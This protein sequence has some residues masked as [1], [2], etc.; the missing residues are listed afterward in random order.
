MAINEIDDMD[1]EIVKVFLDNVRAE[2]KTWEKGKEIELLHRIVK[3]VKNDIEISVVLKKDDVYQRLIANMTAQLLNTEINLLKRA[4]AK[5]PTKQEGKE[6]KTYFKVKS[7]KCP[8]CEQL[9]GDF[10]IH[11]TK[12]FDNKTKKYFPIILTN[13]PKCDHLFGLRNLKEVKKAKQK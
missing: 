7:I 11:R 10:K 2:V 5:D 1:K 4:E 6:E 13:C 12:V 8:E 3:K 9:F